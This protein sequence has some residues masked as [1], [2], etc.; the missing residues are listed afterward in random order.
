[1]KHFNK[2]KTGKKVT[3]T[4]PVKDFNMNSIGIPNMEFDAYEANIIEMIEHIFELKQKLKFYKSFIGKFLFN[5]KW[6]SELI[7]AEIEILRKQIDVKF[8]WSY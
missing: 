2:F 4:V 5:G 6:K 8:L 7:N 1:M 3:K